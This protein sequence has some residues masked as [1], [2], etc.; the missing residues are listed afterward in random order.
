[1]Y[2][3]S[4]TLCFKDF[5]SPTKWVLSYSNGTSELS[6]KS[7]WYYKLD[8][9]FISSFTEPQNQNHRML[10]LEGH[11]VSLCSNFCAIRATQ[12]RVPG[13]R[14]RHL[15]RISKEEDS[16]TSLDR[17]GCPQGKEAF[18]Y[19]QREPSVIEL[20]CTASGPG[21]GH[22]WK[23]HGSIFFAFSLQ[24][25]TYIDKIPLILLQSKEFQLSQHF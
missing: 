16:T 18:H 1:M 8:W 10:W 12:S 14:S 6:P 17:L 21:T 5:P 11:S 24:L 22:Q 19:V 9:I 7:D 3:N 13:P 2:H 15:L 4:W 20:V 23:E 25:F